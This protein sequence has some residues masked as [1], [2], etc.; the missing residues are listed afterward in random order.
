MTPSISLIFDTQLA[1]GLLNVTLEGFG[2]ASYRLASRDQI[3][4]WV[5]IDDPC[6]SAHFLA[7]NY[8]FAS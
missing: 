7:H 4:L 5:K 1:I 8:M 6:N 3:D 2:D